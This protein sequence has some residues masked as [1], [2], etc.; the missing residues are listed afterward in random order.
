MPLTEGS[1]S[2]NSLEVQFDKNNLEQFS[3]I[4]GKETEG[5]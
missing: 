1:N 3:T 4:E 5:L 2:L